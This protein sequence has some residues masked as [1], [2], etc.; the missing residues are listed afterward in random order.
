MPR[1]RCP[2]YPW[3]FPGRRCPL[4]SSLGGVAA[5]Q[6]LV[7]LGARRPPIGTRRPR[8]TF[9]VSPSL[10]L[11][12]SPL[13]SLLYS[14]LSYL[15]LLA[16]RHPLLTLPF[17]LAASLTSLSILTSLS[18]RHLPLLLSNSPRRLSSPFPSL[19]SLFSLPTFPLISSIS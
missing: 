18:S 8:V 1:G 15:A 10:H 12:L 3:N 13:P 6:T 17:L 14:P 4:D 19:A 11:P 5:P 2:Q 16:P 9:S 7:H